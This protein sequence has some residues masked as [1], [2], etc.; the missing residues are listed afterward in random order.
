VLT[1]NDKR[2]ISYLAKS[3][4]ADNAP[5]IARKFR[6]ETGKDVSHD[7]I[8]RALKEAGFKAERK[9]KKPMLIERHKKERKE[10]AFAHKDWSD[11][12]WEHVIWS[13][14]TII[15]YFGIQGQK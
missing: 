9:K 2:H 14:E 7:T 1:S 4:E 11:A 12:D 5:K 8:A 6:E 13:D 3:G 15:E 10:W